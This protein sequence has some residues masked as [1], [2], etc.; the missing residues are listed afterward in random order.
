M[1]G[2]PRDRLRGGREVENP[3]VGVRSLPLWCWKL[4]LTIKDQ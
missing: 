2:E 3:T 4:T 1:V